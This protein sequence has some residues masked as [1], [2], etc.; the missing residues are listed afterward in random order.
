MREWR[1]SCTAKGKK[2]C[3]RHIFVVLFAFS[4]ALMPI[5]RAFYKRGMGLTIC[6]EGS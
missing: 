2:F 6:A 4:H 3:F 1:K 5:L